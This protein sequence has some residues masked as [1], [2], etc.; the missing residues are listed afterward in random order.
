MAKLKAVKLISK[1][2]CNCK[3]FYHPGTVFE[4]SEEKTKEYVS[5]GWAIKIKEPQQEVQKEVKSVK[6]TKN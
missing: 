2:P 3:G 5:K 1:D 6:R 4:T